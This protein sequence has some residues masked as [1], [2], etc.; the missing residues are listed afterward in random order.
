MNA[1]EELLR[2]SAGERDCF[3]N[4]PDEAR[5]E[6]I[7]RL[8]ERHCILGP[9]AGGI[10]RLPQE[11]RPSRQMWLRWLYSVDKIQK[12][13]EK[14][15]VRLAELCAMVSETGMKCCLLK[16]LSAALN[17]PDRT[18]RQSGDID[19]WVD[20]DRKSVLDFAKSRCEVGEVVYHHADAK[21]FD[22]VEVELHFTPTW[23]FNP[24]LNC[25]LQNWFGEQKAAQMANVDATIGCAVTTPSFNLVYSVVHIF[26]HI[27]EQGIG[28]RQMMDLH[29]ALL[30]SE[31]AD[32]DSAMKV[33]RSLGLAKLCAALMG[34]L[35][36]AFATEDG[37][38]LCA[39]DTRK[40]AVLYRNI[41]RGGNFGLMNPDNRPNEG[42]GRLGA[43][44]RKTR[45]QMRFFFT[46]PRE[47]FWSPAF[48]LWQYLWRRRNGWL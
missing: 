42:E 6:K 24:F 41:L 46:Y 23:M 8:A 44:F 13:N 22:D 45:L 27:L 12:N 16:G 15:S 37:C 1:F 4:P 30:S 7:F 10:A 40:G 17:Y 35:K 43:Y 20:G 36:E 38:L 29:Y 47:L 32:R 39:P 19:L 9:L 48:K 11:Q 21:F 2:I 3:T 28:L 33:I 25:R 14:M 34:V 31:K 26:R 5:W 18:V